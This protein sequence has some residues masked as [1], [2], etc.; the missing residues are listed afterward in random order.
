MVIKYLSIAFLIVIAGCAGKITYTY[1]GKAFDDEDEFREN[2]IE[3]N[4]KVLRAILPLPKPLTERKLIIVFPDVDTLASENMKS[5][6][7]RL[8]RETNSREVEMFKNVAWSGMY[9]VRTMYESAKTR[10]IY[11]HVAFRET[12]TQ[13]GSLAPSAEYD[14]LVWYEETKG[15][16]QWFYSS[17]K[18]GKQVF[19]WDRTSKDLQTNTEAFLSALQVLAIRE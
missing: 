13:I 14:T 6:V 9:N 10:N 1:Q 15:L 2:V 16:G 18:Y 11:S 8:K 17:A 4:S 5:E 12:K 7:A 19:A 3:E